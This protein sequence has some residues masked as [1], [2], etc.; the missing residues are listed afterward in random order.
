MEDITQ[1]LQ[2][3]VEELLSLVTQTQE[4]LKEKAVPVSK[5]FRDG[6]GHFHQN[7]GLFS[8]AA[9]SGD[10]E[11][12][13]QAASNIAIFGLQIS[14]LLAKTPDLDDE[15]KANASAIGKAASALRI[16]MASL[17]DQGLISEPRGRAESVNL[18]P[19]GMVRAKALAQQL[20]GR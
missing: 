8:K 16:K 9:E 14:Q 5:A 18:T 12:I 20:F 3:Q 7:Y 1:P 13:I 2:D 10:V 11:S 19:D 15:V 4:R 6:I 17:A